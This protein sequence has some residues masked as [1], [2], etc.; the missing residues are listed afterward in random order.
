VVFNRNRLARLTPL[1]P[2]VVKKMHVRLGDQVREGQVLA[3]IASP[4]IAALRA[5]LTAAQSRSE[6]AET[7]YRREKDLLAKGVTSRQE[8]EQA[9]NEWRQ[10]RSAVTQARQ[11]LLDYGVAATDLEQMSGSTLPVRAPFDGSVALIDTVAGEAVGPGTPLMTLT[12]LS[13]LW[14][15]LSVPEDRL[16]DVRTGA[17]VSTSFAALPG[18]AFSGE[19]FWIA[20]ALDEKTRMLQ[21]LARVDNSEGLLR[22]G[23]FGDVL[24]TENPGAEALAVP[25]DALQSLDGIPYVFVELERDLYELRRVEAGRRNNGTVL[26]ARGLTPDDRV[27]SAQGFA[28]KSE[29]LKSRLGA[30]CADH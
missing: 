14:V 13:Q 15:D 19:I 24:L 23:M 9:E 11:Q 25:A 17:R 3:E 12:D 4:E 8:F 16:L 18:R 27:V 29:I 5:E 30:S 10:A 22:K 7:V 20:P 26:I 21:V 1:A 28:L 6:L 2:G